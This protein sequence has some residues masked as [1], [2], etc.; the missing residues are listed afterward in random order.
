MTIFILTFQHFKSC[1]ASFNVA[2]LKYINFIYFEAFTFLLINARIVLIK[3]KGRRKIMALVKLE[4]IKKLL[5]E[6][7]INIK[8]L[9]KLSDLEDVKKKNEKIVG[10]L[11]KFEKLVNNKKMSANKVIKMLNDIT[12]ILNDNLPKRKARKSK[13]TAPKKEKKVEDV[14]SQN[15]IENNQN[16]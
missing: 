4:D 16:V 2:I 10:L 13:S 14:E 3:K 11:D 9:E 1:K 15:E 12:K 8:D 6:N 5:D 7:K